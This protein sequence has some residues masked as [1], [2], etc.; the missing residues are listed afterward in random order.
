MPD[1]KGCLRQ[2]PQPYCSSQHR[3][4]RMLNENTVLSLNPDRQ[5]LATHEAALREH[6]F[7]V[8][9]VSAPMEARFEIEMGRC[10]VFLTCDIVSA[11]IY[12]DLVQLFRRNCP[13]G[14]VVRITRNGHVDEAD[15]VLSDQD[16][17]ES[18]VGT[19]RARLQ[20]R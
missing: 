19:I 18:I 17:P 7:E 11:V 20:A 16:Q 14:L 13:K 1:Q 9:S 10:G 2:P 15:V 3:S 8:I 4:K 12:S 6:G 5:A